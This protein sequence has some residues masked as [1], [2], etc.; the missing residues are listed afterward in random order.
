MMGWKLMIQVERRAGLRLAAGVCAVLLTVP[1]YANGGQDNSRLKSMSGPTS[2]FHT[3]KK[4]GSEHEPTS[5]ELFAYIHGAMLA[6]SPEDRVNDNLEISIDPTATVLTI[7]QPDGHCDIFL[8]ALDA[9]TIVWDVYDASDSMQARS[10]LARLTVDAVAGKKARTCYD[11]ENNVDP[12]IPS[13]RARILFSWAMIPDG[14]GFQAK[15][16]KALKKLIKMSG[17]MTDKDIFK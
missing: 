12:S 9:N 1:V 11:T 16:T 2:T 13:T 7:K 4:N 3:H 15:F 5:A 14:S 6:Y 8:N 17:G 10:P